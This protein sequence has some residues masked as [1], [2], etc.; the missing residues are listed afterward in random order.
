MSGYC[1]KF[2]DITMNLEIKKR[3]TNIIFYD[4]DCAFC[5]R[6]LLFALKRDCKN[7]FL[8]STLQGTI[9]RKFLPP[10]DVVDLDTVIVL[11]N[12]GQVLKKS[13]AVFYVLSC[14][15]MP[16]SNIVSNMLPRWLCDFVYDVVAKRR[17]KLTTCYHPSESD[18]KVIKKRHI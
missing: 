2:E 16:L 12:H 7:I 3:K 14:I 8:I 9:A 15:D 17:K 13:A 18:R 4:G 10:T 1:R 5:H 6:W 11:N